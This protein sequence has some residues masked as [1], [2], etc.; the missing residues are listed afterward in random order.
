[1]TGDR[2]S[3]GV[4]GSLTIQRSGEPVALAGSRPRTLLALLLMYRGRAVSLDE[5]ADE[6]W[7]DAQPASAGSAVHVH[8]SKV[9]AAVG[10]L[11]LKVEGGY[12]LDAGSYELDADRFD[13]AVAQVTAADSVDAAMLAEALAL[14]RGAP[15]FDLPSERRLGAWRVALEEQR[16][17][18]TLL[19]IDTELAAGA[20]GELVA[21]LERL[22]STQPFEERLWE[23]LMLALYRD[24][25]QAQALEAFQRARR[26]LDRELGLEPGERLRA[27]QARILDQD[28]A[29][30][31]PGSRVPLQLIP[32]PAT[33]LIGREGDL[34]RVE[35]IFSQ[36]GCRLLTVIGPGG[37]GK[38]RLAI[39]LARARGS[40]CADGVAFV[41]LAGLSDASQI[42]A[43]IAAT[44]ARAGGVDAP[45]E[46]GLAA[47]L[48]DRELMLVL[49]NCEHLSDA[50]D[51][52]AELISE[53]AGLRILAT[54]RIAL[55]L[56]GEHLFEVPPLSVSAV[57]ASPGGAAVDLFVQGARAVNRDLELDDGSRVAVAEICRAVDG[58][59]LAIELI[60]AGARLL[61]VAEIAAQL[62]APLTLGQHALRDL[63]DRHQTL[64]AAIA[65][66]YDLLSVSTQRVLRLAAVFQGAFEAAAL[67]AV[68]GG[69]VD[70]ELAELRNARLVVVADAVPDR[71]RMLQL[72]RA[73]ARERL[74]ED[75]AEAESASAAHC[76]YLVGR[77]ATAAADRHPREA[78]RIARAMAPDHADLRAAVEYA[79]A[80]G[81]SDAAL[82]LMLSLQ[83]IWM[84]GHLAESVTVIG[85]A[86]EAC[87]FAP[88]DEL[89]LL[90]IGSFTNSYRREGSE[91]AR[92]RVARATELGRLSPLVSATGNLIAQAF[93][94]RDI[95]EAL[96]LR[97]EL[98]A[99][100]GWETLSPR[101]RGAA[102][103]MRS[104][105]AYIENDLEAALALVEDSVAA[106]IEGQHPHMVGLARHWRLCVRSAGSGE[107]AREELTE[108][109]DSA[110]TLQIPDLSLV[111][112]WVLARYAV[113][114]DR[115][116]AAEWLVHGDRLMRERELDLWPEVQLRD[117]TLHVLKV[118][119]VA[120]LVDSVAPQ[121]IDETLRVGTE[122][123]AGR[124]ARETASRKTLAPLSAV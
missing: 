22:I 1:M 11:L 84:A 106:A 66:G 21:E 28:P 113:S 40:D 51:R 96:R 83:P 2:V 92:R 81:D 30:R 121:E 60:A 105:C 17:Q 86:L 13:S 77:Y 7:G 25:R 101:V 72:V 107:I 67:A 59:P 69:P 112:V 35:A 42:R 20:G 4:L 120:E 76:A 12:M 111:T 79:V 85:R 38:T 78:G 65:W 55:R 33:V 18:A 53:S 97:D 103:M 110:R 15:L 36:S 58:L 87:A 118:D 14:W 116:L 91:W 26:Q 43:E 24:A 48:A 99:L 64:S 90:R 23:Q 89:D 98:T 37:I 9:R 93:N 80:R 56:R 63:P 27:L 29:L 94:R 68:A 3:F 82:A 57:G 104:A 52:I 54:S 117:E 50:A 75:A 32:Q 39:E 62:S 31:V 71:F 70:A 114:F 49:D 102:L 16:L 5:M 115:S 123:L 41:S 122:W 47:Y 95:N 100:P 109:L 88:D 10:D 8:L 108:V 119:D 46:H 45:S 124:P 34:S 6:L 73:F 74:S 44:L 19:R 61:S